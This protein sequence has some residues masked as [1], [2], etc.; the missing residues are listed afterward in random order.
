MGESQSHFFFQKA[1][2]MFLE[3]SNVVCWPNL[4]GFIY[5]YSFVMHCHDHSRLTTITKETNQNESAYMLKFSSVWQLKLYPTYA[6]RTL[7]ERV[8]WSSWFGVWSGTYWCR[9]MSAEFRRKMCCFTWA[10][11][12]HWWIEGD[13]C[14]DRHRVMGCCR[15]PIRYICCVEDRAH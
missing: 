1:M 5:L 8:T 13:V 15:L 12:V 6:L 9:Q 11:D 14:T 2:F 4:F 7:A 3:M 10:T